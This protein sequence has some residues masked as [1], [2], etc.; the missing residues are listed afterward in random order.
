MVNDDGGN[1]GVGRKSG[2]VAVEFWMT[3][4]LVAVPLTGTGGKYTEG[5]TPDKGENNSS[6][7]GPEIIYWP[8]KFWL[9]LEFVFELGFC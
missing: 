7:T 5:K 4:Q 3:N 1:Q 9:G 2:V 6:V 8:R